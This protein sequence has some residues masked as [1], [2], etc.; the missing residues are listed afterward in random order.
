M[1]RIYD[2]YCQM[3][4]ETVLINGTVQSD[5]TQN[6]DN[7]DRRILLNQTGAGTNDSNS[8]NTRN[9]L[10]NEPIGVSSSVAATNSYAFDVNRLGVLTQ[11]QWSGGLTNGWQAT[12]LNSLAQVTSENWS[13]AGSALWANGVA[14]AASTVSLT[15]DGQ[16]GYNGVLNNV[17]SQVEFEEVAVAVNGQRVWKVLGPDLNGRYGGVQGVGGIEATIVEIGGQTTPVLNDYWGNVLATIVSG[18][19]N[20]SPIRVS[21]YGPVGAQAP[22]LSP[23][24]A[25]AQTLIWRSREMDPSGFYYMGARYYDPLAGHFLSP[26]PLGHAASADLYSAFNGDPINHFDPDGRCG[27]PVTFAQNNDQMANEFYGNSSGAGANSSMQPSASSAQPS[28]Q[29]FTLTIL[30]NQNSPQ[31]TGNY[32]TVIPAGDNSASAQN[33]FSMPLMAPQDPDD[34]VNR[35]IDWAGY[36]TEQLVDTATYQATAVSAWAD[37]TVINMPLGTASVLNW[38]AYYASGGDPYFANSAQQYASA[39]SPFGR[40]G[41]YNPS[42]PITKI[43]NAGVIFLIPAAAEGSGFGQ[44]GSITAAETTAAEELPQ[45]EISASQYPDLAENILNAQQAGNP[46]VL[47]AGGDIAADRAAA[48]QGVPNIPGLS[49]DEYPFASSMEGGEGAWVGHIPVSQQNAQGALIKNF[50]KANNI[51]PGSQYRVV[52]VP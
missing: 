14:G 21:G 39:M 19:A 10:T 8:H 20:W 51:A 31:A 6:W 4:E 22:V 9:Q 48:L 13:G 46:Q 24:V 26:D 44:I 42:S 29:G 25:L 11:A 45:L 17:S 15:L 37:D 52:I 40:N 5:F 3:T 36:Y 47:T 12:S 32:L 2:A 27:I 49:R 43:A 33:P 50:M 28:A 1:R 7:D 23:S 30:P 35:A 34:Y 16:T 18:Q 41:Y 38:G